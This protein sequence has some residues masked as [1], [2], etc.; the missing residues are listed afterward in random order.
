M[1]ETGYFWG[2][3]IRDLCIYG[4]VRFK[5]DLYLLYHQLCHLLALGYQQ[6]LPSRC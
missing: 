3:Q 5:C 6:T 4:K 2:C 1:L